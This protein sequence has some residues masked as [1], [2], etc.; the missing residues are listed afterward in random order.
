MPPTKYVVKSHV[1]QPVDIATEMYG[2]PGC[3]CEAC[4]TAREAAKTLFPLAQIQSRL[5]VLALE[6]LG[7]EINLTLSQNECCDRD[8]EH[9]KQALEVEG[10]WLLVYPSVGYRKSI[11]GLVPRPCLLVDRVIWDTRY[12]AGHPEES[13]PDIEPC[14]DGDGFSEDEAIAFVLTECYK[15]TLDAALEGQ[16]IA[17]QIE[18]DVEITTML[19]GG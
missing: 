2:Q 16:A 19:N 9:L 4:Q 8:G 11:V 12:M 15:L 7:Q 1:C 5:Q 17:A 14:D 3:T 6:T 10:G 18:E 13:A